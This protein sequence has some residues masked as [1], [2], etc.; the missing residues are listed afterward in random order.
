MNKFIFA[1]GSAKIVKVK[2]R[3]NANR[4]IIS[5]DG[6]DIISIEAKERVIYVFPLHK[7]LPLKTQESGHPVVIKYSYKDPWDM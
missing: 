4:A 5:L 2:M 7:K 6:D 1:D 3:V